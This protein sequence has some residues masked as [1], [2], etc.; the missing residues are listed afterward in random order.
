MVH[1]NLELYGWTSLPLVGF[2]FRAY[3]ADRGPT[4]PWCRPVLWAWSAALAVG[5]CSWLSLSL[6]HI[7]SRDRALSNRLAASSHPWIAIATVMPEQQS[8][9]TPAL[10]TA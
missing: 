6:I 1:M 3:G 8:R 7:Y 9:D 4:A 10:I 5:A 2:L